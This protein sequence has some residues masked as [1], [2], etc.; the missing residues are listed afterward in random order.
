V[1]EPTLAASEL[2]GADEQNEGAA[3]HPYSR[4]IRSDGRPAK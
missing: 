4:A 2:W 1:R 3:R